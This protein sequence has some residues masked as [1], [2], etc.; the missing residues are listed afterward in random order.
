MENDDRLKDRYPSILN[1]EGISI[2]LVT[3]PP[4]SPWELFKLF[5]ITLWSAPGVFLF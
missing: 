4:G 3:T 5:V 1:Y 2:W